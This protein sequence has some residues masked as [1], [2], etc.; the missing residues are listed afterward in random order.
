MDG[1]IVCG[2][3]ELDRRAVARLAVRMHQLFGERLGREL[4]ST[5][6]WDMLLDLYMRDDHRPMSLT[7]L[8][9]ASA[10]PARTAL[11]TINRLVERNLLVRTPDDRDGRRVHVELSAS[12]TRLLDRC[13]EDLFELVHKL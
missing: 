4:V 7:G 9:G 6:A 12:A 8:C 1:R 3:R 5:P 13:F 2:G 11:N 10:V